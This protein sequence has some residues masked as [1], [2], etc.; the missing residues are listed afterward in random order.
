MSSDL[1]VGN[2]PRII[3]EIEN[4]LVSISLP[5]YFAGKAST[6]IQWWSQ[7]KLTDNQKIALCL[8]HNGAVDVISKNLY[9]TN[10]DQ[11]MTAIREAKFFPYVV[12]P[13]YMIDTA[14]KEGLEF[15]Y[16]RMRPG[17]P[18]GLIHAVF[19]CKDGRYNRVLKGVDVAHCLSRY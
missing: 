13:S 18:Y 4:S 5:H 1:L 16:F 12:A 8:V 10:A 14:I 7:H 17:P 15:G 19:H 2:A 11:F 9:F 6:A 3:A